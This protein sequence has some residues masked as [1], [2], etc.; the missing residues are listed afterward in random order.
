MCL[1]HVAHTDVVKETFKLWPSN[2][3]GKAN[4]GQYAIANLRVTRFWGFPPPENPHGTLLGDNADL[5]RQYA[6]Y[7]QP[8]PFSKGTCTKPGGGKSVAAKSTKKSNPEPKKAV[9][10]TQAQQKKEEAAPHQMWVESALLDLFNA[11]WIAKDPG[12]PDSIAD[13]QSKAAIEDFQSKFKITGEPGSA[14]PKTRAAL[15]KALADLHDGK[16]NPNDKKPPAPVIDSSTGARTRLRPAARSSSASRA[17]TSSRS[18]RTTSRSPTRRPAHRRPWPCRSTQ[19]RGRAAPRS[20]CRRSLAPVR[21]S[22]SSSRPLASR[23]HPTC[24]CTSPSQ[25]SRCATGHGTRRPG[26]PTC[27]T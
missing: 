15:E 4:W 27:K 3:C 24:Y 5:A 9:A 2:V 14:G 26:R 6:R 11:R 20:R 10:P 13:A 21:R 18:A 17:R 19:R 22:G 23:R 16:P 7:Q 12:K 1:P 8:E 25:P